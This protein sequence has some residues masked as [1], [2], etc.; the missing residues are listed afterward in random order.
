MAEAERHPRGRVEGHRRRLSDKVLVAFHQACDQGDFEVAD[1]LVRILE[2]VLN[3]RLLA[4]PDRRQR[5][6]LDTL[7]AAHERFWQLRHGVQ[8]LM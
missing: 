1:R 2:M 3:R 6:D 8:Q 5:G 7:V 4:K